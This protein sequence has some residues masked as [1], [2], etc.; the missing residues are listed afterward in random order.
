MACDCLG[1][2]VFSFCRT[3]TLMWPRYAEQGCHLWLSSLDDVD[4]VSEP[5]MTPTILSSTSLSESQV[6][7]SLQSGVSFSKP[8]KILLAICAFI[9]ATFS[10]FFPLKT[11]PWCTKYK[12][13]SWTFKDD[14]FLVRII[15]ML[16]FIVIVNLFQP[17]HL[18]SFTFRS[19][20]FLVHFSLRRVTNIVLEKLLRDNILPRKIKIQLLSCRLLDLIC[21]RGTFFSFELRLKIIRFTTIDK[22]CW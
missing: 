19:S 22:C 4:N 15:Q 9:Y 5:T 1:R 3:L 13:S 20:L 8:D 16:S 6:E 14:I 12:L 18:L 21:F 17:L 2:P 11:I 10:D 7:V